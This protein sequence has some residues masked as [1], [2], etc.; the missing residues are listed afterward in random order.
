MACTAA[1]GTNEIPALT[2]SAC[3]HNT[4]GLVCLP[5]A[6]NTSYIPNSSNINNG[7]SYNK[8]TVRHM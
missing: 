7:K 3:I 8:T 1:A 6:H 2:M 4:H 5:Q